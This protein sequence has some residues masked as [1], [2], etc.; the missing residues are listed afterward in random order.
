MNVLMSN[1]CGESW[2]R[3][4]GGGSAFW[5]KNGAKIAEMDDSSSGLL[6]IEKVNDV[7]IGRAIKDK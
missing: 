2:G 3:P 7:W 5:S 4:S 6:I 1:F